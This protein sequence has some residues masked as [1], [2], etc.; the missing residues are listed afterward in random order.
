MGIDTE[1][2]GTAVPQKVIFR[3]PRVNNPLSEACWHQL[4]GITGWEFQ[5][6]KFSASHQKTFPRLIAA[7]SFAICHSQTPVTLLWTVLYQYWE[8]SEQR[9]Q[10]I[11]TREHFDGDCWCPEI[12]ELSL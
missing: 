12:I 9:V 10:V 1:A 5:E 4:A 8:A 2:T 7:M 6:D 11:Q 3:E